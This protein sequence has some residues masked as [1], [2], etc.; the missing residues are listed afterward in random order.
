MK[1][2]TLFL[3]GRMTISPI[4]DIEIL[5]LEK[6]VLSIKALSLLTERDYVLVDEVSLISQILLGDKC[7]TC[8]YIGR[9][10][11]LVDK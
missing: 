11:V 2:C 10:R 3:Y 6:D 8:K 9:L 5:I 7:C 1:I 4:E